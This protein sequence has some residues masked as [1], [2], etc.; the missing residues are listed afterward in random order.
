MT[1]QE[2]WKEEPDSESFIHSE[3]RCVLRRAPLLKYW[4]GYVLIGNTTHPWWGLHPAE[5][6]Y[7]PVHGK[8]TYS[9]YNPTNEDDHGSWWV[10]FHCGHAFDLLV[11]DWEMEG[12]KF[13][14]LFKG[15][16]YRDINFA[17][18]QVMIL[19]DWARKA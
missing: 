12:K 17:R 9:D 16:I 6:E 8:V 3:F 5:L 11:W 14:R 1:I 2:Q 7:V 4:E 18:E 19:A 10:G 13:P 15:H